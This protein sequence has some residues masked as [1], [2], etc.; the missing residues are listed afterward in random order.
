MKNL[1]LSIINEEGKTIGEEKISFPAAGSEALL[2]QAVRVF[3]SNQRRAR[4]KAKMRSLVVGSGA[5]IWRQKGTGRARHGS[6]QA[7]LFV[8]GGAAHGPTGRQNYRRKLSQSMVKKALLTV[9]TAKIKEKKISL[10]KKLNFKKTQEAFAFSR[11]IRE[12]FSVEG[13]IAF[14]LTKDE[15]AK[16]YL[17]NLAETMILNAES[18]NPY[19][20]LRAD[21]LVVTEPA[22]KILEGYFNL[23]EGK[24]DEGK[25]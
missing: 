20:L 23:T 25:H 9:L 1:T 19:F 16:R 22:L 11:K 6:R 12:N 8:G 15:E 14:L 17:H 10:V 7:P 4:A 18:L 13:K 3:L 2:A 24:T 5:K 21:F